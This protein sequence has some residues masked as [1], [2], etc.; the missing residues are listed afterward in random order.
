MKE[1]KLIIITSILTIAIILSAVLLSRG[2]KQANSIPADNVT[3]V[4]GKQIIEIDVKGGY[5]P[6]KSIAKAGIPTVVRFKTSR[7][8]DCSAS[9]RIPSLGFSK[10]LPQSGFTEV[11][12]GSQE[13]KTLQGMCGMGMY[14]FSIDFN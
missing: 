12:I 7:T 4:D 10:I 3:I 13:P 11:E 9:V 2:P 1:N 14:G 8:F 6:A 5:S